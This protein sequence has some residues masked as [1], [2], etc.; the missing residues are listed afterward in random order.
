[1]LA[2]IGAVLFLLNIV[3]ILVSWNLIRETE[4]PLLSLGYLAIIAFSAGILLISITLAYISDT[5]DE[6]L[7]KQKKVEEP[8]EST[9]SETHEGMK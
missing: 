6:L 1:M 2:F 3:C 5:L 7:K 4:D 9:Q 8:H